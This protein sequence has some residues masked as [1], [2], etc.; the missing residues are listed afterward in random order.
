MTAELP[1]PVFTLIDRIEAMSVDDARTIVTAGA[2]TG[3]VDQLRSVALTE[4]FDT[5]YD[6]G[7]A[8]NPMHAAWLAGFRAGVAPSA[9][10]TKAR[11]EAGQLGTTA[12]MSSDPEWLHLW[13]QTWEWM[14]L[15]TGAIAAR[16]YLRPTLYDA[17]T[18]PVRAAFGPDLPGEEET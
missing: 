7:E 9:A 6:R 5:A 4:A 2:A 1:E 12:A 11:R 15:A 16:A 13:E 8:S 3:D 10:A 18:R 14:A 17:L